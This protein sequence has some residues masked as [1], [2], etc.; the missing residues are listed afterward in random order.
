MGDQHGFTPHRPEAISAAAWRTWTMNEQ[1]PTA[2]QSTHL[3]V[4]PRYWVIVTGVSPA[5]ASY[6][7]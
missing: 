4:M 7:L 1:P 6:P 3:G 5:I 2:A